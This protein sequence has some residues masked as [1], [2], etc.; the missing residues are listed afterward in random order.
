MFLPAYHF[1][2]DPQVMDH[3]AAMQKGADKHL[4]LVSK[5]VKVVCAC[6]QANYTNFF[7]F[8]IYLQNQSH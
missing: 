1:T 4:I 2:H 5:F 6:E 8:K 7:Y 3:I